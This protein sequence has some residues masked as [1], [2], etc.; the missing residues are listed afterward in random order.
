MENPIK[1]DDLGVPLFSETPIFLACQLMAAMEIFT[2]F[3]SCFSASSTY[4]AKHFSQEPTGD[5]EGLDVSV[6]GG[7]NAWLLH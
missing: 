2:I 1:I 4:K 3:I 5:L 7:V 6:G